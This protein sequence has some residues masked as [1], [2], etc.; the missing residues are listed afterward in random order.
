[1]PIVDAQQLSRVSQ[2]NL[3][4]SLTRRD[5]PDLQTQSILRRWPPG[6]SQEGKP[7]TT[8]TQSDH[9]RVVLLPQHPL[10][11]SGRGALSS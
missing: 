3:L 4:T 6:I 7:A 2:Q 9:H 10:P 8:T 11:V 1:M 5:I